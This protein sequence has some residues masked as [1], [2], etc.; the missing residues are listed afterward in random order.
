MLERRAGKAGCSGEVSVRVIRETWIWRSF[1]MGECNRSQSVI[2]EFQFK[3]R[4]GLDVGTAK[5]GPCQ[6]VAFRKLTA[7]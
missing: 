3:L 2:G 4:V 6:E 7:S 5:R 1:W